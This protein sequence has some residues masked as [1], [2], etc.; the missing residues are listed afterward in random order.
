[1]SQNGWRLRKKAEYITQ[2]AEETTALGM[3]LGK[4]LKK[5]AL[6]CF[7]GDL[8]AGKTTF[9]KGVAHSVSG[10][11]IEEV[12]SPTFV[13]LNFYPPHSPEKKGLYHFDLYRLSDVDEF[14]GLGFEEYFYSGGICCIEW[15]ERIVPILPQGSWSIFFH[16][17]SPECRKIVI[18]SHD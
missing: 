15:S 1:M 5:N 9:I 10:I 3:A 13:Y 12:N 18:E 17:L 8:A 6:L 16:S 4:T 7:F 14:L 2:G 11:A